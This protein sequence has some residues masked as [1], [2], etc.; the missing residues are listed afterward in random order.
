MGGLLFA[1]LVDFDQLF[2]HRNDVQGFHEALRQFDDALPELR[3]ALREDDL[4]FV[5]A[6]HG[7][8]FQD[9]ELPE[10]FFLSE[11]PQGDNILVKNK[12]YVLGHGLKVDFAFTTF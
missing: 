6:D 1:N 8:L 11:A 3:S 7:F 2:G 10:Q 4:L 12:R 9:D 5:T